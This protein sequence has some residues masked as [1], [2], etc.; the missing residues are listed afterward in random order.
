MNPVEHCKISVSKRGGEIDDYYPLHSFI[1]STKEL[2]SDNRH[3]VLHTHWGIRRVIIPIF[4]HTIKISSGRLVDVKDICEQ[5]HILPDYRN[6]FIPTLQ[7]FTDEL[8]DL[9]ETEQKEINLTHIQYN[10]H[11]NIQEL[12]MSPFRITGQLKSLRIT[13]NGWFCNEII[14]KL[15]PQ[16]FSQIE[17]ELRLFEKMKFVEWMDNGAQLPKSAKNISKYI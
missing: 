1:D 4:G 10:Q 17:N 6:K 13:Y 7:D 5:D 16:R 15:F 12:L 8:D 9:N 14:P 2:C 3:R 11:Q